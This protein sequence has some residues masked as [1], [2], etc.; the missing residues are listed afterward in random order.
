M[1][2][3]NANYD[4]TPKAIGPKYT[5]VGSQMTWVQ[6]GEAMDE[7]E[8]RLRYGLREQVTRED[9]LFAA[10]VMHA[11]GALVASTQFNRNKV[12][13][14]LQRVPLPEEEGADV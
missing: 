7:V 9:I 10:S 2:D 3:V 8:H 14:A 11:Y 1:P 4:Y 12:C 5:R 13:G 6:P